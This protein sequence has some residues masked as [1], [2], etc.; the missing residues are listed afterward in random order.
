MYFSQ[1]INGK[2]EGYKTMPSSALSEDTRKKVEEDIE[3]Y[4]KLIEPF[5]LPRGAKE[6]NNARTE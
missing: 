2:M 5:N 3:A 6:V 4:K 1:L